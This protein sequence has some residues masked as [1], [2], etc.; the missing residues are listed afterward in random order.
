MRLNQ[1]I[2]NNIIYPRLAKKLENSDVVFL[3]YGYEEDP[4]MGIELSEFDE[5]NRYS[6]QL[7]HRTATQADL[8]GKDVLEIG[9]GHGGGASYVMRSLN[10]ASYTAVDIN[11]E[12]IRFCVETHE[13]PGLRFMHGDAQD[14]PLADGSFDIVLNVESSHVYPDFPKFLSEVNRLL[15]PGGHFL[16]ADLRPTSSA[17]SEWAEM[18]ESAPFELIEERNINEEVIRGMGP[19]LE[20]WDSIAKRF[21]PS[22]FANYAPRISPMRRNY[23]MMQDGKYEYRMYCFVKP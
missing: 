12:G 6:I 1:N 2:D 4:P 10:P 8:A 23:K 11:R 22:F 16:Y 20:T 7:Y 13:I 14:V 5:P 15:R 17:V 18:L 3:N 21:L 9:C 19:M